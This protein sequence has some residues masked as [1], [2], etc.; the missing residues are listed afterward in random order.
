MDLFVE[1]KIGNQNILE[2]VAVRCTKLKQKRKLCEDVAQRNFLRLNVLTSCELYVGTN[3]GRM[4][5]MTMN[6]T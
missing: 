2:N 5:I 1:L 6:N 4:E 3:A